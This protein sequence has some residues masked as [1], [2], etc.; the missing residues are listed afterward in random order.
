MAN[1]LREKIW[2]RCHPEPN[3]GCWIWVGS[4]LKDGYGQ[5]GVTIDGVDHKYRA[6]RLSYEAFVE[7][8]GS[9]YVCHRC[10]NISDMVKK[11]RAAPAELT[12]RRG[13]KSSMARIS[14]AKA[15]LIKYDKDGTISDISVRHGVTWSHAYLIRSGRSWTHI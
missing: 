14:E 15:K 8:P 7:K 6:H 10:D 9:L 3:S 13:E 12:S 2:D 11:G 4:V 5:I 1:M